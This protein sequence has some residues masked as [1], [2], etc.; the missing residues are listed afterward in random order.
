[1]TY[2]W[3]YYDKLI[4]NFGFAKTQDLYAFDGHINMLDNLDPKL[5]FVIEEVKRRFNVTHSPG[6]SKKLWQGNRVIS[7]YLQP[8]P[9]SNLGGLSR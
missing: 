7:Q 8:S 3:P 2:N 4:T 5:K 9:A 6:E 1:M